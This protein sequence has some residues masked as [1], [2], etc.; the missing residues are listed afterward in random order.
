[1]KTELKYSAKIEKL[2]GSRVKV[3]VTIDKDVFETL[4]KKA[5]AKVLAEVKMDGFRDGKV[6]LA[7]FIKTYGEFPIR[8]EMGY[9]A[10]D[11]TYIQVILGEKI[12]AIGRPEIAIEELT[13]DKDFAYS[14]TTDILPKIELGDYKKYHSK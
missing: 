9:M 8:Q 11:A 4:R 3:M 12:E 14:L 6:P 1:M 13:P 10:V 5:E 7:M 2:E